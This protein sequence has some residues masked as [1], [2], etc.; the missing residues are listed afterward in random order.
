MPVGSAAT[1]L[2]RQF[3]APGTA[4]ATSVETAILTTA[5]L[6]EGIPTGLGGP[7]NITGPVP[8]RISGV[9]NLLAGTA[10]TAVVIRIRQGSGTGGTVVGAAQTIT[11]A[12]AA[13]ASIPF[14]VEDTT[15]YLEAGG[16]YTLTA[17]Q[18]SGTGNGTT[19]TV[20]MEV[21]A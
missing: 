10:T 15:G 9:I 7:G 11:L 20:E 1:V 3:A 12:A 4:P 5:A 17:Q 18:T 16:Q 19:N 21:S 13:S 6:A 2:S 14:S 8:V